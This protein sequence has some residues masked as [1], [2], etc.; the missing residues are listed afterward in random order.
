LVEKLSTFDSNPNS[1][2]R[3]LGFGLLKNDLSVPP[4]AALVQHFALVIGL[5]GLMLHKCGE[6]GWKFSPNI[7]FG[8][9]LSR[10]KALLEE[11]S[12]QSLIF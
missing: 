7:P 6:Y 4:N 1:R 2:W 3:Q 8:T 9:A 10:A 11:L 12:G 5:L